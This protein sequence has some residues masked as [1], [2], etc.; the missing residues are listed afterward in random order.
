MS[1]IIWLYNTKSQPADNNMSSSLV[2]VC[3]QVGS[4]CLSE[5]SCGAD[6]FALKSSA[7]R[8]GDHWVLNGQKAWITNAEHAGVFIIMANI[9][10]SKVCS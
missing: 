2:C 1:E 9:D 3:V 8:E 5:P 10:F 6:A 4:Y 7:K